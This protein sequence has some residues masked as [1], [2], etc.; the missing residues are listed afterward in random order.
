MGQ[1]AFCFCSFGTQGVQNV[2]VP[3]PFAQSHHLCGRVAH[4]GP[5]SS[6]C[7]D[8]NFHFSKICMKIKLGNPSSVLIFSRISFALFFRGSL[9]NFPQSPGFPLAPYIIEVMAQASAGLGE[10]CIKIQSCL[11]LPS[12]SKQPHIIFV[13]SRTPPLLRFSI[14]Q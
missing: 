12:S 8:A 7:A 3:V 13:L 14:L 1:S 4:P 2:G 11:C 5:H 6:L 10:A 9:K